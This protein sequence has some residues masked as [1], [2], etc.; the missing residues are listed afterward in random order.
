[1]DVNKLPFVKGAS[2][3]KAPMFRGIN[4]IFWKIV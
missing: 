1:M 2:I 4:H 3:H